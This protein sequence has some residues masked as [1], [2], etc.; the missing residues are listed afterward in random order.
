ME[1]PHQGSRDGAASP[2]AHT[3][4]GKTVSKAAFEAF[5]RKLVQVEGTWSCAE[6]S[7]GGVVQY[8]A[9]D[10]AGRRY[11]YRADDQSFSLTRR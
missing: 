7:V 4:E 8:E 1:S 3:I 5:E 10:R 6:T 9:R 2:I 11:H